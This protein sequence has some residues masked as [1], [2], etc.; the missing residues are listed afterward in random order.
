MLA[1]AITSSYGKVVGY[2][3]RET[4]YGIGVSGRVASARVIRVA[5]PV[6][7]SPPANSVIVGTINR[8]P[9]KFYFALAWSCSNTNW[10]R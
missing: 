5:C 8:A 10:R 4:R 9:G 3:A 7:I 2:A 6:A 1:G